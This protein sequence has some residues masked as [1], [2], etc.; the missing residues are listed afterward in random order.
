MGSYPITAISATNAMGNTTAEVVAALDAGRSGLRPCPPEFGVS[1]ICGVVPG[2]L[3]A[4]PSALTEYDS[5]LTRIA[6]LSLEDLNRPLA[7]ARRRWGADRIGLILGTSTGGIYESERAY[8]QLKVS[9]EL[10][11]GYSVERQ[12]ALHAGLHVVRLLADLRG[13]SYVVST[14]CSS[15][16]RVCAGA[17][18]LLDAAICDAVLVGGVDSLCGLTL[19]GFAG[20]EVLSSAAC[21]PFSS[22]RAGIN[23][24]EG[25]AWL[26]IERLGEGPARLLGVGESGDA[27]HMTS[28]HPEG[29][30]ALLAMQRAICAGG[31]DPSEIDQINVHGTG[32]AKNDAVEGKAILELLG[33]D[34]PVVA[35]KG[36]TGHLLGA[37]GAT[38]LVL[39][40]A[41]ID[42]GFLPASVGADPVD[43]SI[44]VQVNIERRDFVTKAALSNS[45]AFGGSNVSVLLGSGR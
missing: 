34:I 38:E 45:F 42:G 37:A 2:P 16:S 15:S 30:G 40:V 17:I 21:R 26:L 41:A 20:L 28:P 5:R 10:P 12:H 6:Q 36:Y 33:P 4:L 11:E 25:A 14:A 27:Y 31:L 3:P 8:R 23:I 32:T 1:G 24:G 29:L 35:T 43:L 39:T 18:R 22:E 44:G 13:P 7:A 9:G 19:R